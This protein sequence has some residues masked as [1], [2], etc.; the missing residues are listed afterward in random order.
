[1][2]QVGSR[3]HSILYGGRDGIIFAIKGEQR[4]DTVK[5]YGGFIHTGGGAHFDVVFDDGT[6]SRMLPECI[7]L[8]VQ[9]R[10][11]PGIASQDEI[12]AALRAAEEKSKQ[13]ARDREAQAKAFAAEVVRLK[14]E[15]PDLLQGT[16]L[17]EASKN[18]RIELKRAFP[19]ITFSVKTSR[20]SG[21]DSIDV[22][23]TDG[24]TKDEVKKITDKYQEGYFDGMDD[25][26]H[27]TR[28]PWTETFGSAKYISEERS[29]S[30]GFLLKLFAE[31]SAHYNVPAPAIE[32]FKKGGGWRES[33]MGNYDGSNYWS[34]RSIILRAADERGTVQC[35]NLA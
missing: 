21:G 31:L 34:W 26:Y 30:D 1:M 28:S 25:M 2:K 4:P 23:W 24:P 3:V 27:S 9:W 16:D 11:L 22:R 19:G 32:D 10:E 20:F 17:I 6:I 35:Q 5:T 7:I 14:K 18:I 33:P 8:G 12:R 15:H 29:Y 13:D